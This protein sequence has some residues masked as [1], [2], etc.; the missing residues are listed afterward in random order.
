M[1]VL[2]KKNIVVE[3]GVLNKGQLFKDIVSVKHYF[4][5]L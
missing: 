2:A 1:Q 4:H 3:L 5:V